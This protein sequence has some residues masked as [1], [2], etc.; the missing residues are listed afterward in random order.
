MKHKENLKIPA[1]IVI[2][3]RPQLAQNM[4]MVAR[5]MMN[6]GLSELRLVHPK[7][8]HLSQKA[9][10][11]SSGAQSILEQAKI[12]NTLS[13]ALSDIKYWPST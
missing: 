7:Q 5:A 8:S 10:S 9:F 3:V 2:L 6:C 12:Y 1:P 4:G 11:A 13:D